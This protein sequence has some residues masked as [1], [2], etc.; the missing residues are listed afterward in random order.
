MFLHG[1]KWHFIRVISALL[2]ALCLPLTASYGQDE[3]IVA[4]FPTFSTNQTGTNSSPVEQTLVPEG[5]FAIQLAEVL[6]LGPISD[7]A[8]AEDLLSNLGI[9]PKNGWISERP[10][11]RTRLNDIK[12]GISVAGD[13]GKI[14]F[15]KDQALKLVGD[16]KAKLGLNVNPGPK[17]PVDQRPGNTIIYRYTD[18]KG[19][20]HFTDVYDFIPKE[21][22][23]N[24]RK[25]TR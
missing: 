7:G 13:Q 18:T 11:T 21:Y 1:F 22:R 6:K 17:A 20:I 12:K 25:N 19:V 8:T 14:A 9:K 2:T 15:T 24:A 23:K 10:I 16:I 5:V 3:Q 4:P